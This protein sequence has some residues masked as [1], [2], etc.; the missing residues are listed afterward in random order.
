MSTD[1]TD[2]LESEIQRLRQRYLAWLRAISA[3]RELR[4]QWT[5]AGDTL[6]WHVPM[7]NVLEPDIDL[8]ITRQVIVVRARPEDEPS[9]TFVC[10]LPIPNDFVSAPPRVRYEAGYLEV[11]LTRTRRGVGW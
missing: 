2:H 7:G 9:A 8:E 11:R 5:F 4:A 3:A 6:R 1:I 10:I